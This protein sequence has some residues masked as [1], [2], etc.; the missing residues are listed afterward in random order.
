MFLLKVAVA[1]FN[2]AALVRARRPRSANP[3]LWIF[4]MLQWSRARESAATCD[5][6]YAR[7][8]R[9]RFNGAAL[10][11]A[12]RL[13][14]ESLNRSRRTR[15]NGAALVRA[16]RLLCTDCAPVPRSSFNGAALVRV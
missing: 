4:R 15:F 12:R 3:A 16:R 14:D 9:E 2:G 1:G 8:A 13:F 7:H 10:V 5:K 6:L 11:R